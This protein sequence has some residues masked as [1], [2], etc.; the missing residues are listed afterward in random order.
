MIALLALG[1][2]GAG[3]A[4]AH[5]Q[6]AR[7]EPVA[8]A[9]LPRSPGEVRAW[10]TE[11]LEP[12]FS[13]LTVQNAQNERVDLGNSRV[14]PTDPY[15][16]TVGLPPDLPEGVYT[17]AWK[18]LST[19]DGHEAHGLFAFAVGEAAAAA[20][21][22]LDSGD[23]VAVTSA[24]SNPVAMAVRWLG[25]LGGALLL[26]AL[27][28][29]SVVMLPAL[30]Q[31]CGVA[32][33]DPSPWRGTIRA[34]GAALVNQS[35]WGLALLT[36]AAFGSLAVQAAAGAGT[37]D[38]G[39]LVGAAEGVLTGTRFGALLRLRLLMLA[40][41]AAA[42][43]LAT[44]RPAERPATSPRSNRSLG[45]VA[46][47]PAAP[48]GVRVNLFWPF[49]L[50]V[51]AW[52]M[53]TFSLNSHAAA[54]EEWARW[55]TLADWLHL[56]AASIWVGGLIGLSYSLVAAWRTLDSAGRAHLLRNAVGRFSLLAAACVVVL[57]LTGL[58]AAWLH[59]GDPEALVASDYGRALLVKLAAV[60]VMLGLGAFHLLWLGPRLRRLEPQPTASLA[61]VAALWRRFLG[62]LRAE[63]L[64]GL[65]VLA[66]TAVLVNLSP[67]RGAAAPDI[68]P[69]AGISLSG[70]AGD[71][72][73]VVRVLPGVL[74]LNTFDVQL[75]DRAGN[76]LE[77]VE[78]VALRLLP[79]DDY[80][81]IEVR[82]TP[83]ADAP[84]RF[85]ATNSAALALAGRWGVRV[86]AQRPG[87]PD[88]DVAFPLSIARVG[89]YTVALTPVNGAYRLGP[90]RLDLFV[91]DAAGR[92]AFD[93]DV[94]VQ[95]VMPAH[96]HEADAIWQP[97]G[98]GHYLTR[99][100]LYM[101]GR[102]VGL[103]QVT[104]RGGQP[105]EGQLIFEVPAR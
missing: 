101:D 20:L 65:A 42:L 27:W 91:V 102:W 77:A 37:W 38:L 86:I 3:Q 21:P 36:V 6:L 68:A 50:T 46:G 97:A 13:Q 29:H 83:V 16:M 82:T 89:T 100:D 45:L 53:L 26:G 90:T 32:G 95:L 64:A 39:Q 35:G 70:P 18:T 12:R 14:A 87:K 23:A 9:V 57:V 1:L 8:N 74:G 105:A 55:A 15:Q 98:N 92:P 17:V 58:F 96:A 103:V 22:L 56:L 41:V 30:G 31:C 11:R 44:R 69:P 59:I 63:W 61:A 84:G 47:A 51:S 79:D 28:L 52:A 88:I 33:E 25:F 60:V 43:W 34:V 10:F 85:T 99:A 71:A 66:V 2:I 81:E 72:R 76:P 24:T 49:V 93:A 75:S 78:R 94:E 73:V 48:R 19:E 104:P 54:A 40:V 80:G 4:L 7:S 5:A 62:S 67:P